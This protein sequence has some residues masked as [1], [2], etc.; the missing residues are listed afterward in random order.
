MGPVG[1]ELLVTGELHDA[2]RVVLVT[3]LESGI[4]STGQMFATRCLA[5]N[6]PIGNRTGGFDGLDN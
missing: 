5:Q 2:A 1:M 4:G 6:Q 3:G